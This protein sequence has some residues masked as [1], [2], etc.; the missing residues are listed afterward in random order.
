MEKIPMTKRLSILLVMMLAVISIAACSSKEEKKVKFYEKGKALYEAGENV[1]ARLE[2]SNALQID[3]KFA[4]AY[5]MLGMTEFK[6]GNLKKAYALFNKSVE[7][8]PD[9]LDAHLQLGKFYLFGHKMDKAMEKADLVLS[10]D[11]NNVEAELL[12]GSVLIWEKKPKKALALLARLQKNGVE[13]PEIYLMLSASY[14]QTGDFLKEERAI[15]DGLTRYPDFT[16]FHSYLV[17]F[18]VEKKRMPEAIVLQNELVTLEPEI[19]AHQ[20]YLANLYWET[21]DR[22]KADEL[23]KRIIGNDPMD[24]ANLMQ[25]SRFYLAKQ[26]NALAKEVLNQGVRRIENSFRLN[27]LLCDIYL[28]E[29]MMPEAIQTLQ[30]CLAFSKDPADRG[31]IETKNKLAELFLATKDIEKAEQYAD[32]VLAEVPESVAGNYNKGRVLLARGD[33]VNAVSSFRLVVNERSD[34]LPGYLDLAKSHLLNQ[35]IDLGID[36]LM[37]AVKAKPQSRD[38]RRMLARVYAMKKDYPS[39]EKQLQELLQQNPDDKEILADMGDLLVATKDLKG[40]KATYQSIKEKS[41]DDATMNYKL[42]QLYYREGK[43]EQSTREMQQ[44][45]KKDPRS[46]AIFISLVQLYVYQKKYDLAVSMCENRLEQEPDNVFIYNL[47]GGVHMTRKAYGRAE[48]AFKKALDVQPR[49]L[50][51]Y[52]NLSKLYL[53]QNEKQKGIRFFE[54]AITADPENPVP[55]IALGGF[56]EA[57]KAYPEAMQVYE[58]ALE[59]NPDNYAA[60]NNLAFLLCEQGGDAEDLERALIL[61]TKAND[62]RPDTVEIMDTLAWVYYHKGELDR[63]EK[64]LERALALSS[65]NPAIHYHMGMILYKNGKA[66][67]A[68][69]SLERSLEYPG[70]FVGKEVAEKVLA[71]IKAKS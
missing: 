69:I 42:S 21:N 60:G 67:Q 9:L 4:D 38:A 68:G 13:N 18:Y 29:K 24:E 49:F 54:A 31:I 12:K 22:I 51:S 61:A 43:L 16:R 10:K 34:F 14:K 46:N 53:L 50:L 3:P 7:L 40:A 27:F 71:E 65:K 33:G 55:Y 36:V 58:R 35:E 25:V 5:Y 45:L 2:F 15:K 6:L 47:L 63:A 26:E 62:Q 11:S 52:N 17:R 28:R 56:Y 64:Q 1:K 32:E 48:S 30:N 8:S 20:V 70:P 23:L 37:A 39:A 19:V 59:K 44:A 66:E 57:H 41:P